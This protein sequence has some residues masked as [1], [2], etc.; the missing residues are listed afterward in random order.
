MKMHVGKEDLVCP[1]LYID[2]WKVKNVKNHMTNK[3]E[4]CDEVGDKFLIKN[5]ESQLYLGDFLSSSGKNSLNINK[6]RQKGLVII[7]QIISI[8]EDGFFGDFYFK[9]AV[10]LRESL[11]LN[12]I[13]LN[14][15]VAYNLTAKDLKII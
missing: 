7:N 11:F 8:L 14:M 4:I 5:T 10:L 3:Y 13:L 6:R 12:S 9:A 1:D 15:E 2:T